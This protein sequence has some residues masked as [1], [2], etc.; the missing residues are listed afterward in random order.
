MPCRQREQGR[1]WHGKCKELPP[2]WYYYSVKFEERLLGATAQGVGAEA[3]AS[4]SP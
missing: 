1:R 4:E 3:I 2:V